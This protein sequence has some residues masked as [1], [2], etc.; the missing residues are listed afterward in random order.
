MFHKNVDD[1]VILFWYLFEQ[2]FTSILWFSLHEFIKI[3]RNNTVYCARI[4]FSC[5]AGYPSTAFFF[6]VVSTNLWYPKAFLVV[7]FPSHLKEVLRTNLLDI[8]V[9]TDSWF[10]WSNFVFQLAIYSELDTWFFI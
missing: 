4:P 1:T 6:T 8:N 9:T 10:G 3:I 5:A 7:F 2:F